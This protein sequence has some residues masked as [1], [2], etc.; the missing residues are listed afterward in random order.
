MRN[1]PSADALCVPSFA[2]PQWVIRILWLGGAQGHTGVGE[3]AGTGTDTLAMG[4][5]NVQGNRQALMLFLFF[6]DCSLFKLSSQLQVLQTLVPYIW[7]KTFC[8]SVRVICLCKLL[9]IAW[10]NGLFSWNSR[11]L[12]GRKFAGQNVKNKSFNQM[13][14]YFCVAGFTF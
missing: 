1:C 5:R 6:S 7:N 11:R 8:P 3:R 14:K 4:H 10:N 13:P 9:Q 12:K 2:C